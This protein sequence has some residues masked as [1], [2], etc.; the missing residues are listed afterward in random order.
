MWATGLK[1][2]IFTHFLLKKVKYIFSPNQPVRCAFPKKLEISNKLNK[3]YEKGDFKLY[4]EEASN[5]VKEPFKTK[6]K[7]ESYKH[8]YERFIDFKKELIDKYKDTIYNSDK[9]IIIFIQIILFVIFD[10][11]L[12]IMNYNIPSLHFTFLFFIFKKILN[13]YI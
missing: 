7:F 10:N 6:L 5:I 3:L 1:A 9:K 12:V 11:I 2:S 8:A 4:K 13:L